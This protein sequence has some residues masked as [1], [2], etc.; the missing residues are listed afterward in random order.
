M[1]LQISV[2]FAQIPYIVYILDNKK[3][4]YIDNIRNII[5]LVRNTDTANV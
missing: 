5:T 3:F 4:I 1:Q 2:R